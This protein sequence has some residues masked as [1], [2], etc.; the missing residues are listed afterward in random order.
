MAERLAT[1]ALPKKKK[2][3][4]K[5]KLMNTSFVCGVVGSFQ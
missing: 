1:T 2:K 5:A 4:N 3:T